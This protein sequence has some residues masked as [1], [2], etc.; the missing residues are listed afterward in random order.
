MTATLD[1]APYGLTETGA[2]YTEAARRGCEAHA[3]ARLL[4]VAQAGIEQALRLEDL[5]EVH[6]YL[7]EI[8]GRIKPEVTA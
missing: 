5:D 4:G 8:L 7:A 2:A 6:N 1:G 3:P